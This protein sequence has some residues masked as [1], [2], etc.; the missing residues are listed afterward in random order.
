MDSYIKLKSAG[1]GAAVDRASSATN[2]SST[3]AAVDTTPHHDD[4]MWVH[5]E[6]H[7]VPPATFLATSY[8][9][10]YLD[11]IAGKSRAMCVAN[12]RNDIFHDANFNE[13]EPFLPLESTNEEIENAIALASWDHYIDDQGAPPGTRLCPKTPR[14]D[15]DDD[16]EEEEEEEEDDKDNHE[17]GKTYTWGSLG[18]ASLVLR[19]IRMHRTSSAFRLVTWHGRDL[20][21]H[22]G[23][24]QTLW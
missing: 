5:P 23:T 11:K 24:S 3:A 2:L 21:G 10:S 16:D 13:T 6:G 7:Q 1:A 18:L 15:E 14:E 12:L 20:E 4:G 9:H 17:P 22:F 8:R 19:G